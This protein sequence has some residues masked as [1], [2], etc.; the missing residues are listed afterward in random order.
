M[1]PDPDPDPDP[2]QVETPDRFQPLASLLASLKL[3]T[4]LDFF[5]PSHRDDLGELVR[6]L[7]QPGP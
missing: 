2:K 7:S 1:T 3:S 5:D 4:Y 6:R